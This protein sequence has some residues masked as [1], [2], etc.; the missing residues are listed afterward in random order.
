MSKN[1]APKTSS[2]PVSKI[3]WRIFATRTIFWQAC[4]ICALSRYTNPAFWAAWGRPSPIWRGYRYVINKS[5]TGFDFCFIPGKR[6]KENP[7]KFSGTVKKWPYNFWKISENSWELF[8]HSWQTHFQNFTANP[9]H[10]RTEF[11]ALI[12][13]SRKM[14]S[15]VE[16]FLTFLKKNLSRC[17][18]NFYFIIANATISRGPWTILSKGNNNITPGPIL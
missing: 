3:L 12:F 7:R 18:S 16:K 10:I 14:E 13:Q 17:L 1:P 6:G 4:E 15:P 9:T 8:P 11:H 5:I 2:W